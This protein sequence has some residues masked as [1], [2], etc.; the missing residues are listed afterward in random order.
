MIQ[1]KRIAINRLTGILFLI[2]AGIFIF[3]A[4]LYIYLFY[5]LLVISVFC[6]CLSVILFAKGRGNLGEFFSLIVSIISTVFIVYYVSMIF[7]YEKQATL[8]DAI[9][10]GNTKLIA[11]KIDE[12][13]DVNATED[14]NGR[15]MLTSV[16][17]L[18]WPRYLVHQ[19]DRKENTLLK[20][21]EI[22]VKNGADVNML[23]KQGSA[24]LHYALETW[25]LPPER[26][27]NI[28]KFLIDHGADVNLQNADG[29]TPLHIAVEWN[30]Q[31]AE[32]LLENGANVNIINKMGMTPLDI[33]INRE[34]YE[35]IAELLLKHGAKTSKELDTLDK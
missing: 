29:N 19:Y 28:E 7:I 1:G 24:P 4:F 34:N 9:L 33:V 13:Y 30:Y 25:L 23:D 14:L 2:I 22:L 35:N 21:L 20:M 18:K 15:T 32:L 8:W 31:L 26:V 6:A 27:L 3:M 17:L 16:F 11:K 5:K 10:D 12:G